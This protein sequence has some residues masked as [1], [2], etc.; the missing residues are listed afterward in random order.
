[1]AQA[2]G[3]LP[4]HFTDIIGQPLAL[5]PIVRSLMALVPMG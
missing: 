2:S 4:D 5:S 3:L 1:M